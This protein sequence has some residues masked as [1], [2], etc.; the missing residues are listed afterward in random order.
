MTPKTTPEAN[1][2]TDSER[3]AVRAMV[4]ERGMQETCRVLRLDKHTIARIL[5]PLPVRA[6][7]AMWLRHHL[8]GE[9]RL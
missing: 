3:Q 6:Q 1:Q 7:T 4:D 9:M 5:A 8:P 2:I